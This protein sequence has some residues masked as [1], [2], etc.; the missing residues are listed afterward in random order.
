MTVDTDTPDCKVRLISIEVEGGVPEAIA[1]AVD[2]FVAAVS[3]T[4]Q[5]SINAASQGPRS[6]SEV[7]D[8]DHPQQE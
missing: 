8:D 1:A 4:D 6:Q 7:K 3:T 2:A 5:P